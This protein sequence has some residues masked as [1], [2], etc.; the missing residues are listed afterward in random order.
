MKNIY[1]A[2]YTNSDAITTYMTEKLKLQEGN[3]VLEPSAGEGIFIESILAKNKD[4][5][6][7]ALD[8]NADAVEI[9]KEKFDNNVNIKNIRV[10]DTLLDS[11]LDLY[12]LYGG[13]Y[14]RII[15]NPPY[16]AWQDYEKRSELKKKYVGHYVKETYTLFLLRCVSLLKTNGIL[17]FIIPDT[18]MFLNRHEKLR[19]VLLKN[20]AIE[21]ILIFPSHFFPGVNFG[22]SNLSIIT[23]RKVD[24]EEV[25]TNNQVT[26]LKGFKQVEELPLVAK[27]IYSEKIKVNKLLQK[28]ILENANARFL[29]NNSFEQINLNKSEYTIGDFADIVTGFYSG[30]NIQFIRARDNSVKGAKKYEV[31]DKT[32]ITEQADLSGTL[33]EGKRFI[34]YVKGSSSTRYLREADD[35]YVMW[36]AETIEYY[37]TNKKSRFQNSQFYFRKGIAIPMV[38]SSSIRATLIE[39]RVFDQSIVGIFPKNEKYMLYLLAFLNSD[40][41][42]RM[43]HIINPTANNSSNYVKQIPFIKPSEKQLAEIEE[44]VMKVMSAVKIKDNCL[45]EEIQSMINEH[46]NLL[47][48]D[49]LSVGGE[50]TNIAG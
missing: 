34:P 19:R 16:G 25:A 2:Y 36:D 39:N 23:L 30:D 43:L 47:Y 44:A 21:E 8:M 10:A 1:C 17:S 20:T 18:F 12:N 9:L 45:L 7:E 41:A 22:Y 33:E 15:G 46:F 5:E 38:K 27:G 28:D 42:C 3:R 26:V 37:K 4:V 50:K 32:E 6:I 40:V 35:W 29:L 49:K 13:Y 31:I 48:Y 14:D 11:Q 24:S